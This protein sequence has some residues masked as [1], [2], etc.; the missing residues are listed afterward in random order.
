VIEEKAVELGRMI[1]QTEEFKA[2]NRARDAIEDV[3][4]IKAQT[5]RL[6][7]LAQQ[8]EQHVRAQKDAPEETKQEYEQLLSSIQA[9][10]KYQQLIAAQSNFDKIMHMVNEKILEGMRLGAESSIIIPG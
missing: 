1:G 8:I 10:P 3:S 5:Q 7:M 9:H 6:E 2:V 4:E